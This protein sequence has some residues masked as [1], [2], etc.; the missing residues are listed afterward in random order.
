MQAGEDAAD[1]GSSLVTCPLNKGPL[2]GGTGQAP[3]EAGMGT[4]L[5]DSGLPGR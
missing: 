4:T 2:P 1:S 5:S 3:P